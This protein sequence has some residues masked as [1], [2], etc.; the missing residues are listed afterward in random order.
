M[1]TMVTITKMQVNPTYITSRT[2]KQT[3]IQWCIHHKIACETLISC[4]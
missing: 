3:H 4:I 2:V 1:V